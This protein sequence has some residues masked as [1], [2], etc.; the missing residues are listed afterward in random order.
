MAGGLR[1]KAIRVKSP[2]EFKEAFA[3]A[4]A[5]MEEHQVP[6]V[7][8]C[9]IE[10]VTNIAMGTEITNVNELEEIL[11]LAPSLAPENGWTP[12]GAR[13]LQEHLREQGVPAG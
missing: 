2:D 12:A 13:P 6:V 9:I 11:C 5:L 7:L 10:R 8:E 1:C 3:R 4:E